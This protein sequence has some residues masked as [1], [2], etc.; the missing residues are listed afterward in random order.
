MYEWAVKCAHLLR[1]M[2][3]AGRVPNVSAGMDVPLHEALLAAFKVC[4]EK[5]QE[6]DDARKVL[7]VLI[8]L[9]ER[10]RGSPETRQ[11]DDDVRR[12]T[13]G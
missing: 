8:G 9:V 7:E 2:A 12:K 11:D 4:K 13:Q 5:E 10:A 6:A 1:R 3:A